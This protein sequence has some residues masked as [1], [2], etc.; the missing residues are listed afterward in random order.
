MNSSPTP[1]GRDFSAFPSCYLTFQRWVIF[2][3]PLALFV[4]VYE[5]YN[6]DNNDFVN[7]AGFSMFR[8]ENNDACFVSISST[9]ILLFLTLF[10]ELPQ[11]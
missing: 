9:I 6:P 3:Y 4:Y 8:K 7:M 11:S 2:R 5:K 10:P 1:F